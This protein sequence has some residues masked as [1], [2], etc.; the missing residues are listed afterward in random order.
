MILVCM[1]IG[2]WTMDDGLRREITNAKL[3]RDRGKRIEE[4]FT[5]SVPI[6]STAPSFQ[7]RSLDG[8]IVSFDPNDAKLTMLIFFNPTDCSWCLLETT[9]WREI[10]S[11]YDDD[12]LKILGITTEKGLK[13]RDVFLFVKG[14]ELNFPILRCEVSELIEAYGIT[15]TPTR[16]L[17]HESGQILDAGSSTHSTQRHSR[18]MDKIALLL[19][20][21]FKTQQSEESPH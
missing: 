3:I 7:L 10:D 5:E 1:G 11:M 9:L 14:R 6:G 16:V 2:I 13:D 21:D 15:H 18:L 20:R 4:F 17:V 12:Q 8:K 19:Q